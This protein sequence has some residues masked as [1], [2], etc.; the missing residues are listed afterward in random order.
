MT[1]SAYCMTPF[2]PSWLGNGTSCL[3]L[4]PFIGG[5]VPGLPL[6]SPN[7]VC[8]CSA[9]AASFLVLEEIEAVA[10]RKGWRAVVGLARWVVSRLLDPLDP[11][12]CAFQLDVPR[13]AIAVACRVVGNMTAVAR[14]GEM[15]K[16]WR[17]VYQAGY[18]CWSG[19]PSKNELNDAY[20]KRV[21]WL[22]RGARD[23]KL[24][25]SSAPW[26]PEV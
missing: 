4:R 3:G 14:V 11:G 5:G 24:A 10:T 8:C 26:E 13:S 12:A 23:L 6:T 17:V 18:G 20:P 16:E 19:G 1:Y 15:L 21:H 25:L 9:G 2:D 22:G 7:L